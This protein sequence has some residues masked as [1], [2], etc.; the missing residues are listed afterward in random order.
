MALSLLLGT[1]PWV[2]SFVCPSTT[3]LFVL[4]KLPAEMS[5]SFDTRPHPKM[6]QIPLAEAIGWKTKDVAG[7]GHSKDLG[8][9]VGKCCAKANTEVECRV[10][11]L[12]SQQV[13][14]RS[15]GSKERR[16]KPWAAQ[17]QAKCPGQKKEAMERMRGQKAEPQTWSRGKASSCLWVCLFMPTDSCQN[18]PLSL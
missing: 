16:D 11:G 2:G 1:G 9:R 8:W 15:W 7:E 17:G 18:S 4:P 6:N 13:C 14:R 5:P 3:H 12:S 10:G